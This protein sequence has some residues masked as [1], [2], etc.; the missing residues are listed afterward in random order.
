MGLQQNT[1]EWLQDRLT[2]IGSSDAPIIMGVSKWKTVH[3]LW[4]IKT[5]LVKEDS[6]SNW[7]MRRGIDMEPKAR[8]TYELATDLEMPPA[9]VVHPKYGFIGASL[10]GYDAK[11]KLILEIKCPGREDHATALSGKIPEKY[12]PQVQHQLF[13]AESD[14]LHYF[15]FDGNNGITIEV[16]RDEPYIK[17]LMEAETKFWEMVINKTPP[18]QTAKEKPIIISDPNAKML[19]AEWALQ[20]GLADLHASKAKELRAEIMKLSDAERFKCG[21]VQVMKIVSQGSIDWE[22]IVE[23]RPELASI[24]KEPFRKAGRVSHKIELIEK[25]KKAERTKL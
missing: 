1:P 11:T 4:A 24:D 19:C 14:N 12:I 18:E 13:A 16:H 2:K 22:A 7:A 9:L 25:K 23:S 21:V 10:D 17:K 3:E 20:N 15:S 8:A 5:G 6:G